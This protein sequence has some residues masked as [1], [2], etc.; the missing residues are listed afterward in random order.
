MITRNYNDD[1]DRGNDD[2]DDDVLEN[3]DDGEEITMSSRNYDS[4]SDSASDDNVSQLSS[5]VSTEIDEGMS[6][7]K[8]L[9]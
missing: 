3:V 2:D 6:N 4:A 5:D 8:H 7:I 1:F 9:S